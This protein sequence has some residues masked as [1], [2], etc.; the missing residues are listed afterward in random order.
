VRRHGQ[1][2]DTRGSDTNANTDKVRSAI[3]KSLRKR[4]PEHSGNGTNQSIDNL[5][6][7][8]AWGNRRHFKI[9][10]T[11]HLANNQISIGYANVSTINKTDV[12]QAH[13]AVL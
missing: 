1:Q 4:H 3:S 6:K 12:V 13:H 2:D 9:Q 10:H 5:R 8:H 7:M 11:L